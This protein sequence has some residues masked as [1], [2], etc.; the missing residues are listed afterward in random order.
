VHRFVTLLNERRLM[1]NVEH[2]H[3]RLTLAQLIQQANKSWH[4]VKLGQPDW[5][6]QSRCMALNVEMKPDKFLI[7]AMFNAYWEPLDFELPPLSNG[8][9]GEWRRWID[10]GLRSPHDIVPWR[11]AAPVSADNYRL[12]ARSVAV[13]MAD[14]AAGST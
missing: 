13:L 6:P 3:R 12:G 11:T 7:Y 14:L 4:G 8:A 10:T 9:A 1:R 2:E 5:S